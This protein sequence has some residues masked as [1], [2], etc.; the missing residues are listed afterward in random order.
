ML[1]IFKIYTECTITVLVALFH[2]KS[3]N[4]PCISSHVS[5]SC[6]THTCILSCVSVSSEKTYF[7]NQREHQQSFSA[8]CC[9]KLAER[10]LEIFCYLH[11]FL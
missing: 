8:L 2:E 5:N 3:F 9:F 11:V 7:S 4:R 10:N 6:K 1:Y